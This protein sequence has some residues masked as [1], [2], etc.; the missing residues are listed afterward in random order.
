MERIAGEHEAEQRRTSA[1]CQPAMSN[2]YVRDAPLERTVEERLA[3]AAKRPPR[4]LVWAWHRLQASGGRVAVGALAKELGCSRKHLT[5]RFRR[6]FG[7]S[8]KLLARIP[9]V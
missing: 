2:A 5:L 3:L 8:P 7:V 9:A 6:E 4:D 1:R